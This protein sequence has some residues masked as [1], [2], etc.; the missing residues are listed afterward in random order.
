MI[1]FV[2]IGIYFMPILGVVFCLNLVEILKKIKKDE[3]TAKNTFW[4]TVSFILITW[5]IV[6]TAMLSVS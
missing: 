1:A 2:F 4:L 3:P 5:S 6:I